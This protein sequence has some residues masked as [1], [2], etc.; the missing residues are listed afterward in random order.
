MGRRD[1]SG[2][3]QTLFGG[4]R[5]GGAPSGA[6]SGIR[7]A[8]I[9]GEGSA[10]QRDSQRWRGSKLGPTGG[11]KPRSLPTIITPNPVLSLQWGLLH[12]PPPRFLQPPASCS[13]FGARLA[14]PPSTP[15]PLHRH[16]HALPSL[17]FALFSRFS[18]RFWRPVLSGPAARGASRSF[19]ARPAHACARARRAALHMRVPLPAVLQRR[20]TWARLFAHLQQPCGTAAFPP[21]P[22]PTFTRQPLRAHAC[23]SYVGEHLHT[24]VRP[25]LPSLWLFLGGF[26]AVPWGF[27]T[28]FG[29][30]S[31]CSRRALLLCRGHP[32]LRSRR[33][34]SVNPQLWECALATP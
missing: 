32:Q 10:G 22:P 23:P 28:D 33:R 13:T 27:G 9:A 34:S 14:L 1:R 4:G 15:P 3:S 24:R 8:P 19:G 30:S 21:H 6:G 25:S 7:G 18:G 29:T 12:T 20:P 31:S 26:G 16:T 5:G 2:D 11:S 17:P